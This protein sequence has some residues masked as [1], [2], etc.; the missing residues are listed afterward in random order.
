[1]SQ[2]QE[3]ME[4][5]LD[6]LINNAPPPSQQ[7][8]FGLPNMQGDVRGLT[9]QVTLPGQKIAGM[10]VKGAVQGTYTVIT[11]GQLSDSKKLV[12]ARVSFP[13]EVALTVEV[14][15]EQ[16]IE[17]ASRIVP[18]TSFGGGKR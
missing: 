3:M 6:A 4:K 7:S 16:L 17:P 8:T 10:L 12:V 11:A 18:P 13:A 2:R 5:L 14:L 9:C 1:M 15:E